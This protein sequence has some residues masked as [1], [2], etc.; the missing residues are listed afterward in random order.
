MLNNI[1]QIF[2][3]DFGQNVVGDQT[4]LPRGSPHKHMPMDVVE[5][6]IDFIVFC[7]LP[8]Y[9]FISLK[10]LSIHIRIMILILIFL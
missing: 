10:Y 8:G 9:Y 2:P 4:F 5:T 6:D 3:N 7:E 1:N